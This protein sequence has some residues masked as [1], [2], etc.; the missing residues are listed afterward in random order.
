MGPV[1]RKTVI[2]DK[3]LQYRLLGYNAIYFFVT[4][5][6]LSLAL[7][8]PLIFEISDPSLSPREQA[9]I[10]GKILYLHSYLWP[11]LFL[12]LVILGF[13]SVLVSNKIA[14]PLYRF[15]ATFQKIIEGDLSGT[16]RIRKG[17]LL[18]N[19]QTKI[20]EMVSM[21]QSKI[22]LIQQEQE[23]VAALL[24]QLRGQELSG[25]AKA[26]LTQIEEHCERMKKEAGS[27]K[28]W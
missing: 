21:L 25:P 4:V 6:A 17:D 10:A 9:E 8:T 20:D 15:R 24:S 11:A 12:V 13:H 27:F 23:A 3:R 7:F 14:G 16:V 1:R 22:G 18:I 28:T 26:T 2:V 5:A 19:E